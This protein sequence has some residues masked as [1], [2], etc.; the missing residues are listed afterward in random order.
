M[1]FFN[2][3]DSQ[4]VQ[5]LVLELVDPHEHAVRSDERHL[6][7]SRRPIRLWWKIYDVAIF[8]IQC[9]IVGTAL[10]NAF[11]DLMQRWAGRRKTGTEIDADLA[12]QLGLC[13]SVEGSNDW[14]TAQFLEA[15]V[16]ADVIELYRMLP[17]ERVQVAYQACAGL[18]R[19][20]WTTNRLLRD[21]LKRYGK[22]EATA[23]DPSP[24]VS[25]PDLF[26][27]DP[28]DRQRRSSQHWRLEAVRKVRLMMGGGARRLAAQATIAR[29]L[30]RTVEDLQEWEREL[31]KS[32]DIENDL[33]CTELVGEFY[34]FFISGHYTN[35]EGYKTFGSFNGTYNIAR[36]AKIARAMRR[37]SIADI[38]TGLRASP[39]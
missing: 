37:V 9:Q 6:S 23:V 36:A 19:P 38:R 35:I 4:E 33:L 5:S 28:P 18:F 25:V 3:P 32:S 14:R 2:K 1:T 39:Q 27:D 7:G 22:P 16:G 12:G 29:Q 11:P 31:V 8:P 21:Y 30:G 20:P 13:A 24:P 17:I 34:D 10:I 15:S 26:P